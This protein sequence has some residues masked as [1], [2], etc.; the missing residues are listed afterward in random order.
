M[1]FCLQLLNP[2]TQSANNYSQNHVIKIVELNGTIPLD[3]LSGTPN[4]TLY[5]EFRINT[6]RE[7]N[8]HKFR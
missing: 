1:K 8:Q 2:V 5:F 6:Y 7:F 4:L 3:D